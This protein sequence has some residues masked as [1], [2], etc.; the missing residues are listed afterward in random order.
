VQSIVAQGLR[1]I[2]G[3]LEVRD[4]IE[5]RLLALSRSH[6]LLTREN[7]ESADLRQVALHALEPFADRHGSLMHFTMEGPD[8]RLPPKMA[9]ALGMAFHELAT[10]ASKYGALRHEG[11]R[12]DLTWL[13]LGTRQGDSL[14]LLWRE[15][16]GPEVHAPQRKGFGSRLLEERLAQELDGEVGLDY[17]AEGL[18]CQIDMPA[19]KPRGVQYAQ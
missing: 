4:A 9:L 15:R 17:R 10:N 19:P 11:G 16:G 14:R 7:W 5:A 8:V 1:G 2:A 18:I 12:I 13:L 3:G 6:D